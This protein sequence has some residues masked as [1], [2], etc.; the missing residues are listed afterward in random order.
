VS[1]QAQALAE[2]GPFFFRPQAIKLWSRLIALEI[3]I[4]EEQQ[5]AGIKTLSTIIV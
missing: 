2:L 4:K 5:A 3:E 1:E